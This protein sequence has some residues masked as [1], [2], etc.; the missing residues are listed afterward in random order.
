M[1]SVTRTFGF[2]SFTTEGSG[3]PPTLQDTSSV[4][5]E[6]ASAVSASFQ[7]WLIPEIVGAPGKPRSRP[8]QAA[9]SRAG[10]SSGSVAASSID[11]MSPQPQVPLGVAQVQQQRRPHQQD[12]KLQARGRA[13]RMN[14]IH[15]NPSRF[16]D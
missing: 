5:S 7:P 6:D 2:S 12:G 11:C 10:S 16:S 1:A 8:A 15:R 9:R 14:R 3:A 13:N 4:A